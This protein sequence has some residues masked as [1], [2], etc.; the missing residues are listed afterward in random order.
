M[1]EGH[2][3]ARSKRH[4][5]R[6]IGRR[7]DLIAKTCALGMPRAGP[8]SLGH[9]LGDL[10]SR[11]RAWMVRSSRE[12]GWAEQAAWTTRNTATDT[13]V[14][15]IN[16][17]CRDLTSSLPSC[18]HSSI[19]QA[20]PSKSPRCF[21]PHQATG[22]LLVPCRLISFFACPSRVGR[23]KPRSIEHT[24]YNFGDSNIEPRLVQCYRS[25]PEKPFRTGG[26]QLWSSIWLERLY[27]PQIIHHASVYLGSIH[28]ID[29]IVAWKPQTGPTF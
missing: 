21:P 9:P 10:V 29:G 2:G 7:A 28:R 11:W 16:P 5:R 23:S 19:F 24:P 26:D 13:R 25:S 15:R 3:R 27:P 18:A 22:V 20:L 12:G 17:K 14:S 4:T 8:R 6:V 1:A